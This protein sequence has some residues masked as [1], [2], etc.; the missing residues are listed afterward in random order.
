VDN[1]STK[2]PDDQAGRV[3]IDDPTEYE[4]FALRPTKEV[5]ERIEQLEESALMAEQRLGMFLIG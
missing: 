1:S 4:K 3:V 5:V 2:L